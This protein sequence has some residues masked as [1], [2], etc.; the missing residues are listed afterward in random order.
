LTHFFSI[1]FFSID[2]LT[3]TS[4]EPATKRCRFE[5]NGLSVVFLVPCHQV[6][7]WPNL[8]CQ[9]YSDTLKQASGAS[10]T[11][12]GPCKG[13]EFSIVVCGQMDSIRRAVVHIAESKAP[14]A[15]PVMTCVKLVVPA[16]MMTMFVSDSS[17]LIERIKNSTGAKIFVHGVDGY[18][19]IGGFI[20]AICDA[21]VLIAFAVC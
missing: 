4:M 8:D 11:I 18:I 17:G 3:Q 6:Q 14:S 20:Q 19:A 9:R 1:D 10:V 21:T 16:A 12:T 2:E 15:F 7:S 5:G 13:N